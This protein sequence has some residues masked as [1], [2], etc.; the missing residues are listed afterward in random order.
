VCF[1]RRIGGSTSTKAVE[2]PTL[3]RSEA[4]QTV[5]SSQSLRVWQASPRDTAHIQRSVFGSPT[6]N[7]RPAKAL[8]IVRAFRNASSPDPAG[9]KRLPVLEQHVP[10][11]AQ[12][13]GVVWSDK[14]AEGENASVPVVLAPE[15]HPGLFPVV[16]IRRRCGAD[17]DI[18]VA[19]RHGG[20]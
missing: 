14:V 1:L 15:D 18:A 2:I 7:K 10:S 16:V 5:M 9:R 11:A 3:L 4:K 20:N 13:I 12:D 19:D 8:M 6:Y 17:I